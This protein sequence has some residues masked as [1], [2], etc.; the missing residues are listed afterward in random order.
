VK[1]L[2]SAW[3]SRMDF[4]WHRMPDSRAA[5]GLIEAQPCDYLVVAGGN[6]VFLEVKE[7]AHEHRIAKDKISQLPTLKKFHYAGATGLLLVLHTGLEKWRIVNVKDLEIGVP[8]WDLRT[9]PLFDSAQ[10]ALLS[11]GLF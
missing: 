10:E 8:S 7:T 2:F 6:V 4:A 1:K 9:F 3:N 11:T 5:R